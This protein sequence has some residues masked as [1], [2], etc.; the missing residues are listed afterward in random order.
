MSAAATRPRRGAPEAIGAR[1][2][3]LRLAGRSALGRNPA[4]PGYFLHTRYLKPLGI[5]QQALASDLGISRRRVNELIRGH[6]GIT[7]DTALR[8]AYYVRNE[9][10]FWL[11]LQLA[12]DLRQA[13][14]KFKP[15]ARR[16]A[17]AEP[18]SGQ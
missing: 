9:P 10:T 7:A 17:H 12:W 13:A 18:Q 8:L 4:H 15:L 2:L 3:P 14:R 1:R 16:A 6:R 5:T 11:H